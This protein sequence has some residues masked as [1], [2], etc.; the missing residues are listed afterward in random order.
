MR[1]KEM[2]GLKVCAVT[3]LAVV[4]VL[5]LIAGVRLDTRQFDGQ[6]KLPESAPYLE[7]AAHASVQQLVGEGV[8]QWLNGEA[9]AQAVYMQYKNDGGAYA[10][11]PVQINYLICDLPAFVEVTKQTVELS[12][13]GSF[14]DADVFEL[15]GS[16][17]NISFEWLETDRTYY[18][19][20]TAELSDGTRLQGTGQF[21]TDGTPRIISIEGVSNMRDIGG[22]KTADGN[23][24]RQGLVYR[25]SEL[26]GAVYSKLH[27]SDAAAEIMTQELGIKTEIDLR[28]QD[29]QMKD[30]L[31]SDVKHT[32]YGV[33]AYSNSFSTSQKERYRE[34]F[35]DLSNKE[36]YPIYVH[37]TY[38]NDRTGTVCYLLELMLGVPEEEAYR[39]WE[40]SVLGSGN[41][42]YSKMD[43]F[44]TELQ[45][46]E[47]DTMQQKVENLLI[48]FGV[49]KIEI[50][51]IR[52]ILI[53]DYVP[54]D[55]ATEDV[56]PLQP[57]FM[58]ATVFAWDSMAADMLR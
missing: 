55:A 5:L 37:G 11:K 6:D 54:R 9:D 4:L 53:E 48:S 19:R 20:I 35:S 38:G 42:G 45:A 17:R 52:E 36:N 18:Y 39:D 26:D 1:R 50:E 49:T 21:A 46:L 34:L 29:S 32:Y 40:L 33:D 47:G 31:G 43:A 44:R 57:L 23:K 12:E 25:G 22:V 30:M 28:E 7:I 41:A 51:S 10:A 8:M 58:M 24:V 2:T 13:S 16:K 3:V 14:A 56:S 27:I 15:T